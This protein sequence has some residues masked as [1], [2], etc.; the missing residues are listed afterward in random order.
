MSLGHRV[1]VHDER[2]VDASANIEFHAVDSERTA[3]S[4]ASRVFSARVRVSP[5]VRE[6]VGHG[7]VCP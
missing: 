1:V 6:D 2:S 7:A 3:S 5:A 4:K